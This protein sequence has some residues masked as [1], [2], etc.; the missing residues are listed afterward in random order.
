MA[1]QGFDVGTPDFENGQGEMVFMLE[2]L[3]VSPGHGRLFT[4]PLQEG[5]RI[6]A[7]AVVALLRENGHQIPVVASVPG[8]FVSWLAVDGQRLGKGKPVCRLRSEEA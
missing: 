6:E 8:T 3:V 2:R 1:K 7:G 5:D 4:E